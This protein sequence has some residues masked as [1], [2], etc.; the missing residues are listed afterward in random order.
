MLKRWLVFAA[1]AP[2]PVSAFAL[3]DAQAA[4]GLF[5][6]LMLISGAGAGLFALTWSILYAMLSS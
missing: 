4:G 1:P 3:A 2:F 5:H 6:C